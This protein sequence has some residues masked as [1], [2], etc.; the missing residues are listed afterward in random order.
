MRT[1]LVD[2]SIGDSNGWK[3]RHNDA[4]MRPNG[5]ER[6]IVEMTRAWSDYADKHKV[7]YESTIGEDGVLGPAWEEIGDALRTLLNGETGN[8]DCGTMDAFLLK[9]MAGNGVSTDTK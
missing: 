3:Q 4:V 6:A 7:R 2:A 5:K 9:T 8:L 1:L